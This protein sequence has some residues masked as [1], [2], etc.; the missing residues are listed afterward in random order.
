MNT[1]LLTNA[2]VSQYRAALNMLSDVISKVP[3]NLWNSAEHTDTNKTWRLLYHTLWSTRYY[4]NEKA[5]DELFWSRAIPGA[6]SLGG[7]WEDPAAIVEVKGF[8]TPEELLSFLDD[9]KADLQKSVE[10]LPLEAPSG[11]EWYPYSRFELHI[12]NI[13][14]IQHHTAQI[15]ER[16]KHN[17]LSNFPWAIDGT[18]PM[19]W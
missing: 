18:P 17:G 19:E 15:I 8:N 11:F 14:H 10:S 3:E 16:L 4:L 1:A 12:N 5:V 7:S 13:R 2:I 9:I 6:E